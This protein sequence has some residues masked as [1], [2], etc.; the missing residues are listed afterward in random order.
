MVTETQQDEKTEDASNDATATEQS[1]ET[2]E[3][4]VEVAES[5]PSVGD[6]LSSPEAL[7]EAL[8]LPAVQEHMAKAAE[9]AENAGK[10]K[11]T[12]E[13]RRQYGNPE[14]IENALLG[15]LEEAG[16]DKSSITRSMRDRANTV[17][18]LGRQAAGDELAEEIPR[19]F[20]SAYDLPQD[21]LSAYSEKIAGRDYDGAFQALVDGAVSQK[22]EVQEK[23]FDK[24][25]K[26]AASEM[27]KA[28]L[29]A[30]SGNGTTPIPATT[31]GTPTSNTSMSLTTAEIERMSAS[32]WKKLSGEAKAQIEANVVAADAERGETT[33]DLGR[34]EQVTS[35]AST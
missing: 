28:E 9:V 17:A 8:A 18:S 2:A 23:D 7:A 35:L 32:S 6:L 10:Q 5:Q 27:A 25:V 15:I 4:E 31:R 11:A 21:T 16:L 1:T 12:A 13:A 19:V 26:A 34:L 20:F 24:R 14:V 33:V 3:A 22:S 30:A 29:A